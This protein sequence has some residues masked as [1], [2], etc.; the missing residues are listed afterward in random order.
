MTVATLSEFE[1]LEQQIL[2]LG[3]LVETSISLAITSLK[4]RDELLAR[5]VVRDDKKIDQ[6]ELE[7]QAQCLRILE[8][9]EPKGFELRYVVAILKINDSLERIGDLSENIAGTVVTVGNWERFQQVGGVSDL[10]RKAEKMVRES[11]RSLA[12]RDPEMARGVI[13]YDDQVDWAQHKIREKIELELDRIPENASPLL[14]LENVTRQFERMGD[15]ACNI[16]EE[17]IYIVEGEVVRHT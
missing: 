3:Q 4:E 8:E 9:L 15:V 10:A 14:R 6:A 13:A 7:V 2:Q 11:L 16:A 12:N 1:I 17:V 5:S